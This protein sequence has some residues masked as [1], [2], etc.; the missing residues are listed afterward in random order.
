MASVDKGFVDRVDQHPAFV[1]TFNAPQKFADVQIKEADEINKKVS[2]LAAT[3]LSTLST[4]I[5]SYTTHA[6]AIY[7]SRLLDFKN[8]PEPKNADDNEAEYTGN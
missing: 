5:L 6:Q 1:N 2:S 4:G 7:T 3:S 8:L